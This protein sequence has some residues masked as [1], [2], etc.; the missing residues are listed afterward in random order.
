MASTTFVTPL[1]AMVGAFVKDDMEDDCWKFL[2]TAQDLRLRTVVDCPLV[3]LDRESRDP[4]NVVKTCRRR[5]EH[6]ACGC[7]ERANF[8]GTTRKDYEM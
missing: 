2:G 5:R 6:T 8:R 7:I 1:D 4:P 3:W